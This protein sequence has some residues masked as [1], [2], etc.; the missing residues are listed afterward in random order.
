MEGAWRRE[1]EHQSNRNLAHAARGS[2]WL[3][4]G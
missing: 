4:E 1:G 3:A 2:G